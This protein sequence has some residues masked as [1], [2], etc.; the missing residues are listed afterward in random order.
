MTYNQPQPY[1]SMPPPPPGSY[2]QAVPSQVTT[3]A[4]LLFIS[5]GFAILGGLIVV[6]LASVAAVFVVFGVILL[7]IGAI[8]IWIGVALRRLRPWARTA[9]IVLAAIGAVL[10][11]IN[12][13]GRG[14]TSVVGLALDLIIIYLLTRPE[15]A[16]AFGGPSR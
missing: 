10:A 9:A 15:V 12:L 16:R 5:G 8:D 2:G 6:A 3:A 7:V 4:V 13:I 14:Y 11:V 1:G